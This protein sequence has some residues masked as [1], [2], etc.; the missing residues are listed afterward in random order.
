MKKIIILSVIFLVGCSSFDKSS[1]SNKFGK[2]EERGYNSFTNTE[3]NIESFSYADT[4]FASNLKEFKKLSPN[5]KPDFKNIIVYG[6]TIYDPI[7]DFYIISKEEPLKNKNYI[8][9]D[10]TFADSKTVLLRI[11]KNTPK[12]DY[13]F[14]LEHITS[15]Q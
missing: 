14:I 4:F 3:L 1:R 9:I 8:S 12:S 7:Y 15:I 11:S 10:T 13:K 6:K 5:K 2:D